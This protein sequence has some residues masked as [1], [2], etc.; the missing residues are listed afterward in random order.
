[1]SRRVNREDIGHLMYERNLAQIQGNDILVE[2]LTELIER[3]QKQLRQE[4]EL[5]DQESDS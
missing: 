5:D 2:K 3:L 4:K 1:M